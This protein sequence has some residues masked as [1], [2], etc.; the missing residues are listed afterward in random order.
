MIAA[1]FFPRGSAL[2]SDGANR[3]IAGQRLGFCVAVLLDF[4][5]DTRWNDRLDR[6]LGRRQRVEDLALV[7][8]PIAA[9]GFDGGLDLLQQRLDLRGVVGAWGRQRLRD[10]LAGGFIHPK[11][12]LAPRAPRAHPVLPHRPLALAIHFQARR[13]DDQVDGAASGRRRQPDRYVGLPPR[14]G[15]VVRHPQATK[16]HLRQHRTDK[17][18]GLAQGQMI[19][20]PQ[21]Q[22]RLDGHVRKGILRPPALWDLGNT[23]PRPSQ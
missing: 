3:L 2:F 5:I 18:L 1:G 16:P 9:E 20:H 15:G 17:A 19:D 6:R 22:N 8:G 21:G 13:V 12:E 14:E 23:T 10:D 7:I 11:V 4:G